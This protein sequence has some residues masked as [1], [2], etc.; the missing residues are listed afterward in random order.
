MF[1]LTNFVR[2]LRHDDSCQVYRLLLP[3]VPVVEAGLKEAE[4]RGLA[5]FILS[6]TFSTK[7]KRRQAMSTNREGNGNLGALLP[8]LIRCFP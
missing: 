1:R 6:P 5:G 7:N 3:S 8:K 2:W 4:K